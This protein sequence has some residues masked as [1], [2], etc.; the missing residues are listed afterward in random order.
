MEVSKV[1]VPVQTIVTGIF[2]IG[3][4]DKLDPPI[5]TPLHPESEHNKK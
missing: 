1:T 5:S 3:I 4:K 2:E